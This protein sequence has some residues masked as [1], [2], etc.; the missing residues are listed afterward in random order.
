MTQRVLVTGATGYIGGR[1]VPRLLDA[2]HQVRVLVR[3]PAKLKAVPWHDQV[4]IVEGDLG[5]AATVARACD[6]VRTFFYLVH[7]MGSGEGFERKELEMARTV[8]EAAARAD[9][10]RIVYLG[11]LHP[12]GVELSRHMRSR[13]AVGRVLLEG[14]VPAV[15]FQAGVV[16]GSGSASFEMI[17]H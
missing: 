10:Q 9:V 12:D 13:T 17:R 8:A 3:S 14:D 2:G 6:G 1:L 5:D 7:S 4:E 16:I 15:V 11:G